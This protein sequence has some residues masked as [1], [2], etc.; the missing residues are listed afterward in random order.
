MTAGSDAICS[1]TGAGVVCRTAVVPTD[2]VT[3]ADAAS[4]T[5][6]ASMDSITGAGVA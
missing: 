1:I 4:K 2:L 6:G 3:G 5:A